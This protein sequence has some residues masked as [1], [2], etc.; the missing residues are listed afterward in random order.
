MAEIN[1]LQIQNLKII[2]RR[3]ATFYRN[4][5]STNLGNPNQ[6]R[7]LP[8]FLNPISLP[9]YTTL[10]IAIINSKAL[11]HQLEQEILG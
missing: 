3:I 8:S 4:L 10:S 2:E 1:W 11:C 9:L 7:N 5:L 6:I